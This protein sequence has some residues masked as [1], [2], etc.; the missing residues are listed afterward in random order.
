MLFWILRKT[1]TVSDIEENINIYGTY[2]VMTTVN[3]LSYTYIANW[4]LGKYFVTK[5]MHGLFQLFRYALEINSFNNKKSI[6]HHGNL[7][8]V[9]LLKIAKSLGKASND[10][11]GYCDHFKVFSK[12]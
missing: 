7:V 3:S 8:L 4:V 11:L 2:I 5:N 9:C 6:G 10:I 12:K 1:F